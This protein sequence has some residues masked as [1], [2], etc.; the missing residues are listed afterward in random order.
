M[1]GNLAIATNEDINDLSALKNALGPYA[2]DIKLN[3]SAVLREDPGSSLSAK[4]IAG[5]ALASAYATKHPDVINAILGEVS[6]KLDDAEINA[7]KAAATM[8]A[9]NNVYYRFVHLGS[10]KEYAK[11][12]A[13]LR[14]N[15]V[16]N[17]GIEKVDFELYSLAVS[18]INGCGMCIDAHVMQVEKAGVS[19][20]GIQHTIRIASVLTA[21]AQAL[22]IG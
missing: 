20:T 6:G 3:L 18:A 12:A 14:M 9:M 5:I 8:M 4:Q 7:A 21:S 11:M 13:G 19:K 10:D 16:G 15:V 22:I 2:K 1:T 17:P